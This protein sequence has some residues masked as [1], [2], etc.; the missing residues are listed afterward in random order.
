[1][2]LSPEGYYSEFL[3]GRS[4]DE[5][6]DRIDDLRQEIAELKATLEDPNYV[7]LT[8]P[9]DDMR[10]S[11]ARDYL[12]LAIQAL[13]EA[14]GVYAPTKEEEEAA[15]FQQ[16]IPAI[17]T[18]T[19]RFGSVASFMEHRTIVFDNDDVY[20]KVAHPWSDDEHTEVAVQLGNNEDDEPLNKEDLLDLVA[21][22][23]IGEWKDRYDRREYDGY[24]AL[25]GIEWS[26]EIQYADGREPVR[27]SGWE[28]FPFS[29]DGIETLFGLDTDPDFFRWA[30]ETLPEEERA[31]CNKNL[32]AIEEDCRERFNRA[33]EA[34]VG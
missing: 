31:F 26:L 32:Q 3:E 24:D 30:F 16:S 14:G 10:L 6:M 11:F 17:S 25:D 20:M 12:K 2:L 33:Y 27:K 1:M 9:D 22:L 28:L 13:E 15:A 21:E 29:F 5:I 23:D 7:C 4:A 34:T 8:T 18:M 19:L